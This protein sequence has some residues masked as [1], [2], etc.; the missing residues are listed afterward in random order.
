MSNVQQHGLHDRRFMAVVESLKAMD[1]FY[2]ITP[3]ERDVL[4]VI[5]GITGIAEEGE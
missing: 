5:H 1:S 3:E 2:G 4:D